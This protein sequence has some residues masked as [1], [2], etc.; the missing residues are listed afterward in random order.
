MDNRKKEYLN[1]IK[2]IL[3]F[4]I[5]TPFIY[6][7]IRPLE[8]LTKNYVAYTA[9]IFI[10]LFEHCSLNGNVIY[11]NN[12]NIEVI[13]V[14]TGFELVAIYLALVLTLSRNLK[15]LFI[16]LPLSILVYLGNILRIVLVGILG[17][18]FVNKVHI[19]HDVVGYITAPIMTV[20]ASL[21]YLKAL[22]KMR[23]VK[24]DRK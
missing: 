23:M 15:E 24:N 17:V 6:L 10:S 8:E 4:F 11:L 5:I 14:C 3:K 7:L 19:I 16:G 2:I 12:L 22:D 13:G 18:L 9:Y 21:I 1:G 20:M